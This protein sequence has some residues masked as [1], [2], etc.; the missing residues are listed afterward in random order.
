M[1]Q[2]VA[3]RNSPENVLVDAVIVWENLFGAS[4]E[5]TLRIS[6]ALA[7]LLGKDASDREG[8]Q[9]KF[10]SLYALRSGIVHGS[11]RVKVGEIPAASK[12]TVA[13]SLSVLRELFENRPHLLAVASSEARGN[14]LLLNL[15]SH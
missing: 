2:A 1:L 5:T 15:P 10:K 4:Q 14:A 3:E 9:K 13:I 7:W 6:T 12:E 11:A 8:L